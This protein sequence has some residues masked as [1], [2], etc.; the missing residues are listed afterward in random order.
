MSD[1]E[2]GAR[3]LGAGWRRFVGRRR[4]TWWR[5]T[6]VQ[7]PLRHRRRLPSLSVS[8]GQTSKA[9]LQKSLLSYGMPTRH[10]SSVSQR[11]VLNLPPPP[12]VL[13]WPEPRQKRMSKTKRKETDNGRPPSHCLAPLPRPAP[14][15]LLRR[16]P[17]PSS[18]GRW[19][20]TEDEQR[21]E[22]GPVLASPLLPPT[23]ALF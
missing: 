1:E 23:C 9:I 4:G 13:G 15:L 11:D 5:D 7:R 20:S 16:L 14:V 10:S 18:P 3:I 17:F 21:D 6:Q 22:P 12:Q 19:S 8:I 2:G